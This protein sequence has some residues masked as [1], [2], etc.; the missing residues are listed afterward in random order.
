MKRLK[1][2]QHKENIVS[3]SKNYHTMFKDLVGLTLEAPIYNFLPWMR[4]FPLAPGG[5]MNVR[6]SFQAAL[7]SGL[8]YFEN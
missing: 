1:T 4:T 2:S 8:D 6:K 5:L 7:A 3:F